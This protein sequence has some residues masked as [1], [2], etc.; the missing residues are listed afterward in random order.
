[1]QKCTFKFEPFLWIDKQSKRPSIKNFQTIKKSKF[2]PHF[3]EDVPGLNVG[4]ERLDVEEIVADL[5]E[6]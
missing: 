6:V 4:R 3:V 1:M 5:N 2:S